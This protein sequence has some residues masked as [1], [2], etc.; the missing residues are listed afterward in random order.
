MAATR[1]P[2]LIVLDQSMQDM[3]G[4]AVLHELRENKRTR[5][6]PTLYLSVNSLGQS[7]VEGLNIGAA[8][9]AVM[10]FI[11]EKVTARILKALDAETA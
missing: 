7:V 9:Q 4:R 8:D 1:M 3:D 6:I 10:P 5:H 2:E 11:P